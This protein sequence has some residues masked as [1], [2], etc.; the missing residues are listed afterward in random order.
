MTL[1]SLVSPAM[2]S[3]SLHTWHTEIT[4]WTRHQRATGAPETTITVRRNHLHQL[5]AGVDVGPWDLDYE[6]LVGWLSRQ[7]WAKNTRRSVRTT[8]RAF[9]GWALATGRV[10]ESPAHLLAPIR[11]SRGKPRPTPEIVYREALA[12]ADDRTRLAIMLAAR[13]GLRRGEIAAAR[14]D[15]VSE[16]LLGRTLRVT[17]KGG[18]VRLVPL[19]D[20]LAE[21]IAGRPDGWLFPSP[22]GGHL[23][24]HHLGKLISRCLPGEWT[25]HTLRHRCG[26]VAYAATRDLR[27]VQELLGHQKP[28]TT[29]LYTKV[30]DETVRAAMLAAA[31]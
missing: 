1:L 11:M 14:T 26:T 20:D 23:T 31:A 24:P 25:T 18:H 27:A 10:S 4:D 19:P 21:L 8:L 28:E 5:A 6:T 7:A 22:A 13:C 3:E 15:D 17:G 29:A 30:P 12:R 9:Y 16:D 2:T